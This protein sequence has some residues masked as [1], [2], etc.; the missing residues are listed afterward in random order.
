MRLSDRHDEKVLHSSGPEE[1][2]EAP[3]PM[4]EGYD[5]LPPPG[6]RATGGLHTFAMVVGVLMLIFDGFMALG[7]ASS[8]TS[9][10]Q[11]NADPQALLKA[12]P[13]GYPLPPLSWLRQYLPP[14]MGLFLIG[15]LG[16]LLLVF[17][18]IGFL[19]RKRW[20]V[21]P[22]FLG[23]GI[24]LVN[25][26]VLSAALGPMTRALAEATGETMTPAEHTVGVVM[27]VIF[28]WIL[29]ALL[30]GIPALVLR[31]SIRARWEDEFR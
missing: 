18:V 12:M 3:P 20:C 19:Q 8:I 7:I 13:G 30:R 6:P 2:P 5:T 29:F 15:Q 31:A 11:F 14:L 25:L 23:F 9:L 24:S 26:I 4:P 28:L 16:S 1:E 17:G 21:H 10:L 22:L 27:T